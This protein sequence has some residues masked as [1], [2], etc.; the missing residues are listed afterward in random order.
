MAS[1]V[2]FD[3]EGAQDDSAESSSDEDF[4][5][6]DN[7]LDRADENEERN[8]DED[9]EVVVPA[10]VGV[11]RKLRRPEPELVLPANYHIIANSKI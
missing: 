8:S 11:R 7:S 2:T 10:P 9:V 5:D 6:A 3:D 4:G 1:E